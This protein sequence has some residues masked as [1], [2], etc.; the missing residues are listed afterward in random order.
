MAITAYTPKYHDDINTPDNSGLTPLDKNYLRILFQ[1]GRTVQAREL[2]QAQ[3]LLQA[4][5]DRL[6]QSLFKPNSAIVGGDCNFD[7]TLNFIDVEFSSAED[8]ATFES[9]ITDLTDITITSNNSGVTAIP[10][11]VEE[12]NSSSYRLFIQYRRGSSSG[13]GAAT[14]ITAG[15]VS[16]ESLVGITNASVTNSGNAISATL[17]NGVFFVKGCMAIGAEQFVVRALEPDELFDGYAVLKIGEKQITAGADSTLFD[18]ANG[19][20]NFAAPG[21]DRYQINLTLNLVEDFAE[22]DNNVVLL[23]IKDNQVIIVENPIDNSASTLENI[24]A[25]RTF[26]ESGSYT[27]N[28]FNIEL[29]EVLGP[30][31]FLARYKNSTA[32]NGLSQSEAD[33]KYAATLSPSVAY[34]RGK[35]VELAGPLTLIGDKA[36]TSAADLRDGVLEDGSTV[37]AMGNYVE[38]VLRNADNFRSP[39]FSPDADFSPQ[40]DYSPESGYGGGDGEGLPYFDNYSR[41]YNLLNSSD[42]SIGTCKILTFELID[43][44]KHRLFLHAISLNT[45]KKFDDV[46]TIQGAAVTDYGTLNFSVERKDGVKLH[47]TQFNSTLFKL[48]YDTVKKFNNI[49]VTERINLSADMPVASGSNVTYQ[50]TGVTFDK[51][52][53]S[54]T[55]YNADQDKVLLPTQFSVVSSADSDLLTL[56][57]PGADDGDTISIVATA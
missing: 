15:T 55:V 1:P 7:S 2:N 22:E 18:N 44:A 53:S 33:T 3:S 32:A 10:I 24:L 56:N 50:L 42:V 6:G 49:Q 45:G 41:T 8:V 37:A 25:E 35:R 26:E 9:L 43:G 30:D 14:E 21:A 23:E 48:P 28:D 38:G 12:L 47:D 11:K 54:I 27:V 4:Q 29:Q 17:S 52:P 57:V 13:G 16:I 46:E 5:L 20:P 36:R 19:H 31:S 40:S 39:F 51:S 34:V